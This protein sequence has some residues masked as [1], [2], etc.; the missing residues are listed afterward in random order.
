[1]PKALK[2]TFLTLGLLFILIAG[3]FI[4]IATFVNPNQFKPTLTKIVKEKTGWNLTINGDLNWSFLPWLGL[5]LHDVKLDNPSEASQQKTTMAMEEMD[6]RVRLFPLIVGKIDFGTVIIKHGRLTKDDQTT[7]THYEL[8][9]LN[10]TGKNIGFNRQMPLEVKFNLASNKQQLNGNVAFSGKITIQKEEK[11]YEIEDLDLKANLANHLNLSFQ[12]NLSLNEMTG[13][14]AS[15]DFQFQVNDMLMQGTISGSEMMT[16]PNL[17]GTVKASK[18]NLKKLINELNITQVTTADPDA[19]TSVG[20]E[21][22]FQA[23]N[24]SLRLSNLQLTIDKSEITG[25]IDYKL[26]Q[27]PSVFNVSIDK[28]NLDSYLPSSNAE[29]V[30]D[31]HSISFNLISNANAQEST[32]SLNHKTNGM[33]LKGDIQIGEMIVNHLTLTKLSMHI[34]GDNN[35]YIIDPIKANFYQGTYSG[36]TTIDLR[37]HEPVVTNNGVL[38]GVQA[39]DLMHDLSPDSHIKISGIADINTQL[40]MR[41]TNSMTIKKSLSGNVTYVF[42]D[43]TLKGINVSHYIDVANAL[44]D[45][46]SPPPVPSAQETP[47]GN[48]TGTMQFNNGVGTTSNTL[49]TGEHISANAKGSMNLASEQLDFHINAIYKNAGNEYTVPL[50]LTGTFSSPKIA[51]DMNGIAKAQIQIQINKQKDKIKNKVNDILKQ[52]LGP[53]SKDLGDQIQKGLN[54]LL[55]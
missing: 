35:V 43:G 1:M 50:F 39:L 14:L 31:N 36:S 44:L 29:K 38:Q 41:G 20:F 12:T 33:A 23:S 34:N 15:T 42:K 28:I 17:Q 11:K 40:K 27:Q 55:R 5:E 13:D 54:S 9:D 48:L 24:K 8:T 25:D 46:K 7:K 32:L 21:G 51:P 22:K 37:N 6:F 10:V 49:L 4:A 30:A 45:K 47:F 52:K 3:S 18:F 2:I 26:N 16:N 53:N 19:L